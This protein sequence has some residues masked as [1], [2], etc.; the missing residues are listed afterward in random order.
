MGVYKSKCVKLNKGQ[1]KKTI[2][3][4]RELAKTAYPI[5]EGFGICSNLSDFLNSINVGY[6]FSG[7]GMVSD[8]A[9]GFPNV[10]LDSL[11]NV[12]SYP[13]GNDNY[14]EDARS[15]N[16][17]VKGNRRTE[18]CTHIANRLQELL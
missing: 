3:F 10:E 18:L 16:L 4:L 12:S 1:T 13:L 7:Y 6:G 9:L 8:L 17:W 2:S 5:D 15:N 14:H 11:G